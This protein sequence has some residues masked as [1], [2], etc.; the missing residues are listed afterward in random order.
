M[1]KA[2]P[3]LIALI[4]AL[5]ASFFVTVSIGRCQPLGIPGHIEAEWS[6]MQFG[7]R[8]EVNKDSFPG[9]P[10]VWPG[11]NVGWIDAR[12]WLRYHCY[13]GLTGNY[14]VSYRVAA[15]YSTSKFYLKNWS[16]G[17]VLSVVS[18]PNTGGYQKWKT[19]R[20]TVF[21]TQGQKVL[22][23]F[24]VDPAVWN[25]N[26]FYFRFLKELDLQTEINL[27]NKDSTLVIQ[28]FTDGTF[29][30]TKRKNN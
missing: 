13:V 30:T 5:T 3:G 20:D 14:E 12:D 28:V 24:S 17:N 7:T 18:V 29:T 26:Y 4:V 22:E 21:L 9:V 16:D 23:I 8:T 11:V 6:L 15:V 2:T 10:G 19:V 1:R 27:P 25:L